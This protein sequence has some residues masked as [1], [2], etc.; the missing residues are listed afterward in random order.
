MLC[1]SHG[2]QPINQYNITNSNINNNF[3]NYSHTNGKYSEQQQQSHNLEQSAQ[4]NSTTS[5]ITNNNN[6]MINDMN[7]GIKNT[8]SFHYNKTY[9][10]SPNGSNLNSNNSNVTQLIGEA[11]AN[12]LNSFDSAEV[13]KENLKMFSD[14]ENESKLHEMP[15]VSTFSSSGSNINI[16]NKNHPKTIKECM[17][18]MNGFGETMHNNTTPLSKKGKYVR[19]RDLL[20]DASLQNGTI[21]MKRGRKESKLQ[22]KET[23]SALKE[24]PISPKGINLLPETESQL[25]NISNQNQESI[26][27][28]NSLESSSVIERTSAITDSLDSTPTKLQQTDERV[29][30]FPINNIPIE[31]PPVDNDNNTINKNENVADLPQNEKATTNENTNINTGNL[32]PTNIKLQNSSKFVITRITTSRI[33]PLVT[34][35]NKLNFNNTNNLESVSSPSNATSNNTSSSIIKLM[36]SHSKDPTLASSSISLPT[37]VLTTHSSPPTEPSS[38]ES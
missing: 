23:T 2:I 34:N 15:L 12:N 29:N 18:S 19:K 33:N 9:I 5:P 24:E 30:H 8:N 4:I 21:P 26:V 1:H 28:F 10:N 13:F 17:T 7:C 20:V 14:S 31:T 11:I 32:N 36:T 6:I 27:P 3:T 37:Q 35:T 22:E 25:N 16:S 38:S